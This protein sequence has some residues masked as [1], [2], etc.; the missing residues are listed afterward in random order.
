MC[1]FNLSGSKPTFCVGRNQSTSIEFQY[2]SPIRRSGLEMIKFLQI[3]EGVKIFD[4]VD[5]SVV[6]V[7]KSEDPISPRSNK[8]HI[9]LIS[10]REVEIQLQLE[11]AVYSL[12]WSGIASA[13]ILTFKYDCSTMKVLD[14]NFQVL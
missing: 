8:S 11:P 14:F 5:I 3:K 2:D 4:I 1:S 9:V 7:E 6:I 13:S 10:D 12:V